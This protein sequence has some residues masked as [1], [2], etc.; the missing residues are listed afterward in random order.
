MN[1]LLLSEIMIVLFGKRGQ[2][3]LISTSLQ[4]SNE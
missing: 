4:S 2:A 1:D 3:T